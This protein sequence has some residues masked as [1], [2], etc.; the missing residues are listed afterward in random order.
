[1]L[2]KS[3]RP[4]APFLVLQ[5]YVTVLVHRL[6]EFRKADDAMIFHLI[7]EVVKHGMANLTEKDCQSLKKFVFSECKVLK[8]IFCEYE[9]DG[10]SAQGEYQ[11]L[12][13]RIIL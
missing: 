3:L 9:M 6:S 10:I 5:R 12:F 11:A 1:M 13:F 2:I 7:T 8:A 4:E